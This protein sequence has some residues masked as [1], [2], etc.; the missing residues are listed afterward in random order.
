LFGLG[1]I[2][3]ERAALDEANQLL[4][5]AASLQNEVGE[6]E[7]EAQSRLL[8]GEL[9]LD[10]GRAADAEAAARKCR[11][12]FQRERQADDAMNATR[13]LVRALLAEKKEA[14]AQAELQGSESQATKSQ[15]LW[16][17]EGLALARAETEAALGHFD[18]ARADLEKSRQRNRHLGF[19]GME[20]EVDLAMA[21]TLARAGEKADAAKLLER[22]KTAAASAG[23]ERIRRDAVRLGESAPT[24]PQKALK[25]GTQSVS[26]H[27]LLMAAL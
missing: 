16:I 27:P 19:H 5:K 15:N 23:Y 13:L 6:V 11:E 17:Q 20:L 22:V 3:I 25:T 21:R 7:S 1:Q 2:A 10:Q 26:A 14:Q 18:T 9:A 12:Q 24:S 4:L 8:L